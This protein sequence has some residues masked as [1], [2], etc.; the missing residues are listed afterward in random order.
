MPLN[1]DTDHRSTSTFNRF[2]PRRLFVY[3]KSIDFAMIHNV[4]AVGMD[5]Q[6]RLENL[7]TALG[8]VK[9]DDTVTTAS[10]L[11]PVY[12]AE[13]RETFFLTLIIPQTSN[14]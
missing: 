3:G 9:G 5:P 14:K 10:S 13:V 12:K 1:F 6:I 11:S 7:R 2:Q 8:L 4:D